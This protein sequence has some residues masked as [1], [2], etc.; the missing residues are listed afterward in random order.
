[1]SH[2]Q[3]VR[4]PTADQIEQFDPAAMKERQLERTAAVEEALRTQSRDTIWAPV[5]KGQLRTAVDGATKEGMGAHPT[6]AVSDSD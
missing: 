6:W 3:M 4:A 2:H 5:A 1:M